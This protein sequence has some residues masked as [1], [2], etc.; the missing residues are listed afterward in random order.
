MYAKAK[1]RNPENFRGK[2]YYE[3]P[4]DQYSPLKGR[5][6][7]NFQSRLTPA[8]WGLSDMDWWNRVRGEGTY[9]PSKYGSCAAMSTYTEAFNQSLVSID[10]AEKDHFEPG[11]GL[12][13]PHKSRSTHTM[14]DL[15]MLGKLTRGSAI[16]TQRPH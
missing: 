5:T 6:Q 14:H 13:P 9:G 1:E 4:S 7:G 11:K 12:S 8:T 3:P 16:L 2:W 15:Q 10:P